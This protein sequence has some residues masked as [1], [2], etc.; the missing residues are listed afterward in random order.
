MNE[1]GKKKLYTWGLAALAVGGAIFVLWA[2]FFNRGTL[3]VT[4]K[5][6]FIINIPGIKTESCTQSPCSTVLAPG[7]YTISF[8]KIGY[9]TI[10]ASVTIPIGG[11]HQEAANF[12]FIPVISKRGLESDL[13]LFA[14]PTIEIPELEDTP[15]FFE[16]GFVTYLAPD[17]ETKRQTLYFQ[18]IDDETVGEKRIATSFIRT[19]KEHTIIPNIAERNVI[20]LIDYS[21]EE[22]ATLYLIELTEKTRNNTLSFPVLRGMKWIKGTNDFLFEA[23]E[24]GEISTSIYH[25]KSETQES[26]KLN[27][28]TSIQNVD[29]LAS[30]QLIAATSQAFTGISAP[31][32]LSGQLITLQEFAASP[33][34]T[35]STPQTSF[36]EYDL[37]KNQARLLALETSL[38]PVDRIRLETDGKSFLFLGNG[39]VYEL[40]FGE[41]M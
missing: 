28:K 39:E 7:D 4:G 15:L 29:I 10:S 27:L 26:T 11:E 13:Q 9:R 30:D 17:T 33:K 35:G 25:Y 24:K 8:Q 34:T 6:P 20:A 18:K 1:E 22:Q 21:A 19:I 23:G 5:A 32:Q 31:N 3:T 36:V 14:E 38:P 37:T 16:E 12:Q 2:I 41:N 40:K